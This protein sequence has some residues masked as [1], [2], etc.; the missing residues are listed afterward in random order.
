MRRY[1]IITQTFLVLML[2]LAGCESGDY[3]TPEETAKIQGEIIIKSIMGKDA[4]SV[5]DI[6]C[7]YLKNRAEMDQEIETFFDFIDGAIISYDEPKGSISGGNL[8]EGRVIK[9][10]L[11]GN[12]ENIRT[13]NGRHYRI[14]YG[15]YSEYKEHPE[16]VG[17]TGATIFDLDI[18]NEANGYPEEGCFSI[19]YLSDQE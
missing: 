12:I 1:Q 15:S 6:L 4:E 13:E 16:Y 14:A 18:Y 8:K 11:S 9:E 17:V 10:S 7:P 19:Y 3:I 2:L 5:K